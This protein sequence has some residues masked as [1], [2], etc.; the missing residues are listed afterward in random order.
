M[1]P[2]SRF[3]L[4][5]RDVFQGESPVLWRWRAKCLTAGW[6]HPE[7]G[8][9]SRR[10]GL[11]AAPPPIFLFTPLS[12]SL[13]PHKREGVTGYG[14]A[15]G[16]LRDRRVGGGQARRSFSFQ[17]KP[18]NFTRGTAG[19]FKRADR[20]P[21]PAAKGGHWLAAAGVWVLIARSLETKLRVSSV[22][23]RQWCNSQIKPSCSKNEEQ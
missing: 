15:P 23:Q 2:L 3:L 9:Q 14:G 21:I 4:I 7:K 8:K 18:T 19:C 16:A 13:K 1:E 20:A 22:R 12:L 5:Q 17:A 6:H 11:L 10:G